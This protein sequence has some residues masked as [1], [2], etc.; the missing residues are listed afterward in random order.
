MGSAL[1]SCQARAVVLLLPPTVVATVSLLGLVLSTATGKMEGP[2]PRNR[3]HRIRWALYSKQVAPELT[4]ATQVHWCGEEEVSPS[5]REA[6][7][8]YGL[9]SHILAF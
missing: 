4:A 8:P 7:C 9:A 3:G 2:G 1:L 5:G 6:T